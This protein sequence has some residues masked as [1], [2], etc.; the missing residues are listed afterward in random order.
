[1]ISKRK[2]PP[3]DQHFFNSLEGLTNC[4]RQFVDLNRI[5]IGLVVSITL[6]SMRVVVGQDDMHRMVGLLKDHCVECHGN[7]EL[8]GAVNIEGMLQEMDVANRFKIWNRMAEMVASGKMP[9]P[10]AATLSEDQRVGLNRMI[11]QLVQQYVATHAGDPGP[12]ALRRLTSAEY[13]YT[14]FDLTGVDLRLERLFSNDAVGGEG[15][16]NAAVSQFV[17][18]ASLERYLEAAKRVADHAVLGAGPLRFFADPGDTGRELSAM[19]TIQRIY[20]Q[21]GFRTGAGEGAEPFGLDLYPRAFWVAWQFQN[22]A[23]RVDAPIGGNEISIEQLA[24]REG[25]SPKLCQHVWNALNLSNPQFPMTMVIERWRALERPNGQDQEAVERRVREECLELGKVLREWQSMLAD[26]AGD[27]EEAAVLTEGVREVKSHHAFTATINWPQSEINRAGATA[28]VELSSLSASAQSAE[29]A[30][31]IWRNAKIR[32]RDLEGKRG[33][34]TALRDALTSDS[35]ERLRFGQ[36]PRGAQIGKDDFV[37]NGQASTRVAVRIPPNAKAAQMM[38]DVELDLATGDNRIVR[39]RI[40]DGE[41]EGETAAEIG[42]TST[43]LADP[44]GPNIESWMVGVD[45]FARWLPEVS[46]REP[47]PSD[48]DPIPSLVDNTYNKPERNHFHTAIKYQRQDQFLVDHILDAQTARE[49]DAA[50]VDLL[51][52]FDYHSEWIRF[53]HRKFGLKADFEGDLYAIDESFFQDFPMP[54]RDALIGIYREFHAMQK[55][56]LDNQSQHLMDVERFAADA[57]RRPLNDSDR[58]RLRSLYASVQRDEKLSHEKAIRAV[59]TRVLVS[60]EFL[61]RDES[62]RKSA[63]PS[64]RG[65]IEVDGYTLANRLSYFLWSSMPDRELMGLAERDQLNDTA[66]LTSQ[67]R[68]M[69]ADPKAQRLAAEFFGQWLGFYRFEEFQGIDQ[70]KFPEMTE[71]LRH[72]MY[73][74]AIRFFEHIVRHDRPIEEIV[75]AD[76]TFLNGT[77]VRHYGIASPQLREPLSQSRANAK[78]THTRE[79]WVMSNSGSDA[80]HAGLLGLGAIHAVT[81]AP[82]RTSPVK[83]GD[84]VL[85]RLLGTAVPPPPADAGSIAADDVQ[86]DN[87]T[88]RQRL[89][90]HR[91]KAACQN[92]HSRIDPLGFAL[93]HFDP[94]GRWRDVYRDGLPIDASGTLADGKSIEGLS[95]LREYLK[96]QMPQ[97]RRTLAGKL[98]GYAL[99]RAELASDQPMLDQLCMPGEDERQRFSDFV[100]AIVLSDAF[101]QRRVEE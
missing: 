57:W 67:V 79:E 6:L 19:A 29:G 97:F 11:R 17:D 47:A 33:V 86:A 52:A 34:Y 93:E 53:A 75:L 71:Q 68:R 42:A 14:V 20:R 32:F 58:E 55:Q 85:R 76:Y 74:Q 60:P 45:E 36:H 8:Q 82:L 91:A 9:P 43:L 65:R 12:N 81:S 7:S 66:V 101:R 30:L 22:R 37:L 99:G 1:M 94:I 73:Q 18:D 3:L 87:V 21:H 25:V 80:R 98:L 5:G 51:T 78:D 56:L 77:L 24:R 41:V 27:E 92:C 50:W 40:A 31:V 70:S 83:R 89:E 62:I 44:K 59:I 28:E 49:L 13:A 23:P 95:G 38:V 4:L 2:M 90:S 96:S 63:K 88:V 100:T 84:W 35:I 46:Q 15:F 16:T 69:L 26:T 39:C 72:A 48:R 64:D 61:Y 10:E 54:A